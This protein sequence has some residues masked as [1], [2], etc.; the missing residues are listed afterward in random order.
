M[1]EA[2]E[3]LFQ[4]AELLKT[5][6]HPNVVTFLGA[7]LD[8]G[9]SNLYQHS[10]RMWDDPL[11]CQKKKSFRTR[12]LRLPVGRWTIRAWSVSLVLA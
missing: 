2:A 4:E 6:D 1:D 10:H 12:A 9:D 11:S 5:L 7:C 8:D 3:S